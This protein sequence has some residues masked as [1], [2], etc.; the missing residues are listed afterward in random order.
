MSTRLVNVRL[1]NRRI[2]KARKLREKGVTLSELVR[3]AIDRQYDELVQ[4]NKALDVDALIDTIHA[5]FPDPPNLP[6][7]DHDVHDRRE[8]ARE[9]RQI[10]LEKRK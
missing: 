1:D 6:A 8:R 10:L 7:R 3:D 5:R 4:S 2:E 9:I